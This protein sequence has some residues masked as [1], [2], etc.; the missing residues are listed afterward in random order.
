MSEKVEKLFAIVKSFKETF[1]SLLPEE[2]EELD[3][4]MK[5]EIQKEDK[6]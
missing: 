3:N 1:D 4:L 2:K 5:S 6:Q